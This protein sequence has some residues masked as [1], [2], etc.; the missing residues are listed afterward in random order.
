[1]IVDDPTAPAYSQDITWIVDDWQLETDGTLVSV[2]ND[3]HD[4][5][6]NGRWGNNVTVNSKLATVLEARPGERLRLRLINASN[7]RAYTPDFGELDAQLIAVD[8]LAVSWVGPASLFELA[9]GN[10]IDVDI[11]L[12]ADP[13]SIDVTEDFN[14]EGFLLGTITYQGDTVETPDFA[15]PINEKLPAW[16][17]AADA[18]VDHEY[19]LDIQ[20]GAAGEPEWAF[21]GRTFDD[22]ATLTVT[23]GDFTKIRLS[24][25]SQVLHPIHIHGQFFKV[26]SRNGEPVDEGHFRDTVLLYPG[27]IV[28]VAMV[29]LDEGT[30][31]VHCHIQEHAEAGMI[32]LLDVVP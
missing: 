28:D 22:P 4:I 32:T 19:I 3:P 12:P 11:K 18:N 15:Y 26:V 27:E 6:H 16:I 29:P 2:F 25:V 23:Q 20:A 21:D 8:G 5:T 7:A 30:W 17:E 31:I 10:R 24:N 9:P 13:G 14:G 1:L